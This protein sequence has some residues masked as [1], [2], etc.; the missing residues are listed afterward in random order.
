MDPRVLT[1]V[2][3]VLQRCALHGEFVEVCVKEGKDSGRTLRCRFCHAEQDALQILFMYGRERGRRG[4]KRGGI[5][6]VSEGT[7]TADS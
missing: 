4:Q 1:G 2:R 6:M 3:E 7:H 5:F